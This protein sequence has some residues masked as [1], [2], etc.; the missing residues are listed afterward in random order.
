MR[1]PKERVFSIMESLL[2]MSPEPRSISDFSALF[3]G[4]L[5]LKEVKELLA[6]FQESY[7]K[8]ERGIVVEKIAQGW[9]MRTKLENTESLLK[10]KPPGVFRLSRPSLEVLAIIA[11]EQ[12]C[13]KAQIDEIRGVESGHLLRS[14]IEK[15]LIYLSGKSDLPGKPSLYKT[16]QKFLQVFGLDHLK[17]LPSQEEIQ[18]LLSDT[19]SEE[20]LQSVSMDLMSKE[21]TTKR[22]EKD[23]KENKRIR[24]VLKSLPA[25]VN[26]LEEE[27]KPE[28]SDTGIEINQ[29]SQK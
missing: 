3:K 7:N 2:F 8:P 11:Y 19:K 1:I 6:E 12:P 21:D 20:N 15:D 18:D 28:K 10:I 9:Q 29:D 27:K 25:T 23:E 26:F 16:S 22:I 14:L 5:S 17:D 24:D 13:A 4:E